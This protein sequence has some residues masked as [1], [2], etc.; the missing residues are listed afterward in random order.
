M[1]LC[2]FTMAGSAFPRY[3][4]LEED[5][6]LPFPIGETLETLTATMPDDAIH[7]AT[8]RLLPP[9][10]P[11]KIVCVGRNYLEHAAEL[12]NKMPEEPLLFLKAA[13]AIMEH[14][15]EIRL[16]TVSLPVDAEGSSPIPS[17]KRRFP[18]PSDEDPL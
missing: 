9:V 14:R 16:P 1:K 2:R 17:S 3:G 5:F 7:L 11:S 15:D 10:T 18:E 6:V 12:G 4:Q 8:V 13:A